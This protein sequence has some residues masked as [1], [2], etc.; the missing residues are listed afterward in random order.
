MRFDIDLSGTEPGG[1]NSMECS[2]W[3]ISKQGGGGNSSQ[4]VCSAP[5]Q[6]HR[7]TKTWVLALRLRVQ[8]VDQGSCET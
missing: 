8:P 7:V 1:E 5:L 2:I 3:N 4:R 6:V